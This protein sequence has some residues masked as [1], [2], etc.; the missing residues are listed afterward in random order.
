MENK[1]LL[2][3]KV[4]CLKVS[5]EV[6]NI[7]TDDWKL[8]M[9]NCGHWS[10]VYVS[11]IDPKYSFSDQP[12]LGQR[13]SRDWMYFSGFQ[14]VWTAWRDYKKSPAVTSLT[15]DRSIPR[16]SETVSQGS[17]LPRWG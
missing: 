4:H 15:R 10:L 5:L 12:F 16:A 3:Y 6:A 1:L 9:N 17:N 11:K 8:G 7:T 13:L 14:S 2:K